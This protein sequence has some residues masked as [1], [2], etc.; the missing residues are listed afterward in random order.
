VF[1]DTSPFEILPTGVPVV[2]VHGIYDHVSFPAVGRSYAFRAQARG[3]RAAV[4]LLPNAGHFEVIAPGTPGWATIIRV[5]GE[6][7]AVGAK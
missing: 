4:V 6:R 5:L 7:L 3:D 2:M 1:A